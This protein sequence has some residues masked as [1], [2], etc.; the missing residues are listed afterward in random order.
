MQ[1]VEILTARD[2]RLAGSRFVT[3]MVAF[4]GLMEG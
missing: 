3:D 4:M 1:I 2:G